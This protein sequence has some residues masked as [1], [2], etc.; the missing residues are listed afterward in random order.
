MRI[1]AIDG[2][3]DIALSMTPTDGDGHVLRGGAFAKTEVN[4]FWNRS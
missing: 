1:T 4:A 3:G 2:G